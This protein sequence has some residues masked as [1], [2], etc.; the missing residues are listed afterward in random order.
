M[1]WKSLSPRTYKI[2]LINCL[3]NRASKI[4]SNKKLF[5]EEIS[6][7]KKILLKNS[8]PSKLICNKIH[9]FVKK[10]EV[11]TTPAVPSAP[12]ALPKRVV[13][14][15]LP[16]YNGADDLKKKIT[17]LVVKLQTVF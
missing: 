8:Y 9:D 2:G 11:T 13:Y 15:V 10:M 17:D 16:Y 5:N 1:N 12:K 7:I 14:L 6:K 3:L 4:C